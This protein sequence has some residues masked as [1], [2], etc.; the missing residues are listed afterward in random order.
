[1]IKYVDFL[2]AWNEEETVD[3]SIVEEFW[4]EQVREYFRNP[5]IM[6]GFRAPAVRMFTLVSGN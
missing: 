5:V 6:G 3:F 4:A 1:M 2:N